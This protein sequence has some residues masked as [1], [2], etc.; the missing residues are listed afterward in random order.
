MLA[1]GLGLRR[2]SSDAAGYYLGGKTLGPWVA[3]L[4]ANASSSSAWS[5]IGVSGFA[6][7]FGF[8]ALWLL[9]GCIG[10]FALNWLL[11]A[12]AVRRQTGAA[13]TMTELLAGPAGR[14]G[15]RAFVV[16]VSLLT[17]AS[18]LTYVSA[19]MQ[20]AG[21]T[22]A[23]SFS[24]EDAKFP[25]WLGIVIGGALVILYTLLGGYLAASLTD[26][27]QGLLMAGVAILL[28]LAGLIHVGGLGPLLEAV[29]QVGPDYASPFGT[30]EGMVAIGFAFGLIGIGLGYPGQPHAINKYMGMA[31][32]ASMT[33]AR[34]VGISWAVVLYVG[35]L[36][37]GW[38]VRTQWPLG[39]GA[40]EDA[41]FAASQNLLPPIID[42]I[43][44]A[45]VLAATMST[46]D[47]Q[48]LVCA[49]SVSHD[50]AWGPRGRHEQLSTARWTMLGVGAGA[51]I[52]A[53]IVQKDIFDNVMFAWA[54]L[55]SALGP[56]VLVHVLRGPVA[57]RWALLAA[58][59]G[60]GGAIT[61]FYF[62]IY[63]P[64]FGDRVLAWGAA[65]LI[66]L[67]GSQRRRRGG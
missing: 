56:L 52:A 11:V 42:G 43:V 19:Q 66:A 32:N 33:T 6:Y 47:G 64:G 51:V 31:P 26:T 49:S 39:A 53:L 16:F 60:S 38:V 54:A 25:L 50:L 5:L 23:H 18:L 67:Y 45:A 57:P 13:V 61:T 17:L 9:P 24:T 58:V 40:H 12:P 28:P 7:R 63:A 2:S 62:P 37:V 22:F 44:V 34:I 15:R 30:R 27:V 20:A 8:Q 14:P 10:G 59:V 36:L 65:M 3:A 4:A 41:L 48:M 1:I 46:V 55:G 35:M 29:E 21:G